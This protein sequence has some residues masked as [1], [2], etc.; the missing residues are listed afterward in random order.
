MKRN[1]VKELYKNAFMY[2][3]EVKNFV[4]L[5]IFIFL[6]GIIMGFVFYQNF[7]FLNDF[8]KELGLRAGNLSFVEMFL[9]I[10]Q[11]N[12]SVSFTVLVSGALL[13]FIP[14]LMVLFNGIILGY[15][16]RL[17]V[18]NNIGG[19]LWQLLPHGIFE[20]PAAFISAGLGIHLGMFILYR[21]SVKELKNRIYNSFNAFLFIVFPLLVIAAI[22]ESILMFVL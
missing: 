8:L 3:G 22:I 9:F 14:I 17:L 1:N 18:E 21:D 16:S 6:V 15:V 10:L 2:V 12:L 19:S 4:Y 13:G 5:A 11:N 20:L 7:S